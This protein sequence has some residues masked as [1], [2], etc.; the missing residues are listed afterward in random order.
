M[1]LILANFPFRP[2][3]TVSGKTRKSDDVIGFRSVSPS[4]CPAIRQRCAA[5]SGRCAVTWKKEH[6]LLFNYARH[7]AG[8]GSSSGRRWQPKPPNKKEVTLSAFQSGRCVQGRHLTRRNIVHILIVSINWLRH[9]F[10]HVPIDCS[11]EWMTGLFALMNQ[12]KN[13]WFYFW[14]P[15]MRTFLALWFRTEFSW[16]T[17]EAGHFIGSCLHLQPRDGGDPSRAGRAARRRKCSSLQ[18]HRFLFDPDRARNGKKNKWNIY[19]SSVSKMSNVKVRSA[20]NS[21][22][23]WRSSVSGAPFPQCGNSAFGSIRTA[24]RTNRVNFIGGWSKIISARISRSAA[25]NVRVMG[26]M[27]V[28]GVTGRS[29]PMAASH[30]FRWLPLADH[31]EKKMPKMWVVMTLMWWLDAGQRSAHRWLATAV[32]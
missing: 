8:G 14:A 24:G 25:T 9:F 3:T 27:W 16:E 23:T 12:S 20:D 30:F 7:L 32:D 18:G 10:L 1:F 19:S 17:R 6:F 28:S 22:C 15:E 11:I 13:F 26:P 31:C 21:C 29:S 2:A 4:Q 5:A